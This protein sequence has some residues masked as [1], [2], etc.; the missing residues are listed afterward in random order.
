[1]QRSVLP[2]ALS[3]ELPPFGRHFDKEAWW[4][5]RNSR[6]LDRSRMGFRALILIGLLVAANAHAQTGGSGAAE[7]PPVPAT[8]PATE[9][10][11]ATDPAAEPTPEPAPEPT[12]ASIH[13]IVENVES[14]RGTVWLALC[15]VDLSVEGCPY[16]ISTPAVAGFVEAAFENIP[17]GDY[18]V[19]GYHD[20][21]D[22]NAFDKLLGVPR[23]PYALSA[24]AADMLVPTFEDAVVPLKAGPNDVII[25]MKRLVGG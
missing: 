21:N 14:S 10:A 1:L 5:S 16:K 8:S 3:A 17:P 24:A 13:V 9:P 12:V 23:E 6:N 2:L 18:A 15:N 4:E 25:R 22:S 11:Q 20:V 19:V 7:P